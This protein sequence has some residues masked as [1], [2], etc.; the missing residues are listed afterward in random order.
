MKIEDELIKLA[1]PQFG[2]DLHAVIA[3]LVEAHNQSV[4]RIAE[5]ELCLRMLSESKGTI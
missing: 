2:D 1:A 4:K 3:K 5:L